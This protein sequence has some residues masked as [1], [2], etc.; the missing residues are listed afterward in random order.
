VNSDSVFGGEVTLIFLGL[1]SGNCNVCIWL[2]NC[3]ERK[4]TLKSHKKRGQNY[5][6]F[7][8]KLN[9]PSLNINDITSVQK[10]RIDDFGSVD[11]NWMGCRQINDLNLKN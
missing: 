1:N 6:F 2:Q 7:L 4:Q 3:R 11:Q 5:T 8:L 9:F 10:L